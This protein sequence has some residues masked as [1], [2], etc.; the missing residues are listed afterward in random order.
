MDETRTQ[1]E[2]NQS[3]KVSKIVNLKDNILKVDSF[4]K[5]QSCS[6]LIKRGTSIN[7]PLKYNNEV[8]KLDKSS[9]ENLGV[10]KEAV[11]QL[12]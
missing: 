7:P 4:P 6:P 9:L 12:Q 1:Q 8:K 10:T 5:V 11:M 3:Q 2:T